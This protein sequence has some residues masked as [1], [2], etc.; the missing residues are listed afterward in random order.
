MDQTKSGIF[1]KIIHLHQNTLARSISL[2]VSK[3]SLAFRASCINLVFSHCNCRLIGH[4]LQ[5]AYFFLGKM[6]RLLV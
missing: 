4:Y 5:Y 2:R 1:G 6:M 3:A